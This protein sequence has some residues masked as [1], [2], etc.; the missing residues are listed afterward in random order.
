MLSVLIV[1]V[2]TVAGLVAAG[3][4]AGSVPAEAD[5]VSA[6]QV[7]RVQAFTNRVD[8][9]VDEL[10]ADLVLKVPHG[11]VN[12][13]TGAL[14]SVGGNQLRVGYDYGNG[15]K[16]SM[17]YINTMNGSSGALAWARNIDQYFTIHKV[18]TSGD[19]DYLV[20]SMEGDMNLPDQDA[21]NN[22]A[23]GRKVSLNWYFSFATGSPDGGVWWVPTSLTRLPVDYNVYFGQPNPA[24]ITG[25]QVGMQFDCTYSL[26]TCA[27][28]NWGQALDFGLNSYPPGVLPPNSVAV[29][30]INKNFTSV[31]SGVT[32]SVSTS[33]WYAWVHED[34]S[35]VTSIN[36]APIHITGMT[37]SYYNNS[38]NNYASKNTPTSGGPTLAYT[39]AQGAQGLTNKVGTDGSIDFR[40]AGGT[41]YYKLLVWPESQNPSGITGNNGAPYWD[42][43]AQDLFDDNGH[44]KPWAEAMK[45]VVGSAYYNYSISMPD[46][47]VIASPSSG[48]FTNVNN[49]LTVSGTGTPGNTISLKMKSGGS[50]TDY[51]DPTLAQLANGDHQGRMVGDVVV[52]T[53]GN[54]TYTY[55]PATPLRDGDWTVVATQTDQSSGGLNLTSVPSNPDNATAPTK[56]GVTFTVDTVAPSAV[57]FTCLASPTESTTPSLA[58]SGVEPNGSVKVFE[59]TRL[60]GDAT[61]AG[62]NWTYTVAPALPNGNY[63]LVAKQVD[64]AGNFSPPSTP[65]CA[66]QVA[67]DV[68]I[69]GTAIVRALEVG[70]SES[71]P[72]DS[73]NWEITATAG[74][75]TS[76]VSGGAGATL[77]RN[78]VYTVAERLRSTPDPAARNYAQKGQVVCTDGA[79]DPLPAG[80]FTAATGQLLIGRTANIAEPI[81]C[82]IT[83][84]TSEVTLW[85]ARVG[86]RTVAPPAGWTIS[87]AKADPFSDFVLDQTHRDAGVL[88]MAYSMTAG[89]PKGLSLVG[90]QRL[91]LT[92][93][94]C[95]AHVD[96]A[97][98]APQT[99][100]LPLGGAE[101]QDVEVV[102]GVRNV[103]RIVAGATSDMPTLPLTGGLGSWLFTVGG[104]GALA[105]AAAAYVR[106]RFTS[107]RTS[108]PTGEWVI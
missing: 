36:T 5:F 85:T 66:L 43:R 88:P 38:P 76:V 56:W 58:G 44:V 106:R 1:G 2:L 7:Y 11:Y 4:T 79:G 23:G 24:T 97:D 68:K 96:T 99:C 21:A 100:W 52:D 94:S 65:S 22:V 67:T 33:Y 47:P 27:Q 35:L 40:S 55:T 30:I 62:G 57:N 107:P 32:A 39:A 70:S 74:G 78:A 71:L 25:P 83:N 108:R 13:Q 26:W 18:I 31:T 75:V 73:S 77:K 29:D 102:Q 64:R 59:G 105:V 6:P 54:W 34:G 28:A 89:T 86:G 51:N 12:T 45:W 104:A 49:S 61:V 46:A 50:I 60:L 10:R 14:Q 92:L 80:V 15:N 69:E 3:L 90:L 41:G 9:V 98:Q 103:Y 91:D 84:Q 93:P 87:A 48:S 8:D 72:V 63:V 95:A 20:M 101:T 82:A 42:L 37:P 53:E 17:A 19:N 81:K 16:V